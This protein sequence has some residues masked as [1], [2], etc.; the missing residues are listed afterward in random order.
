MRM[1]EQKCLPEERCKKADEEELVFKSKRAQILSGDPDAAAQP[2]AVEKKKDLSRDS[3]NIPPI[4]VKDET[5]ESKE[6]K[7]LPK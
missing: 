2:V 3:L 6:K 5:Q 1:K 4:F 7:K